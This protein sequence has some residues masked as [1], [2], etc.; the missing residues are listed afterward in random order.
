MFG[1]MLSVGV[2][3]H[4]LTPEDWTEMVE[5][6][7]KNCS[8][9]MEKNNLTFGNNLQNEIVS[10]CE[11]CHWCYWDTSVWENNVRDGI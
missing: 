5:R 2:V 1:I 8:D 6:E 10:E 11:S 3:I 9:C 7:M 4:I